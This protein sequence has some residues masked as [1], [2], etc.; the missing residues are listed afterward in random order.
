M[1]F[2]H[3]SCIGRMHRSC[4][5]GRRREQQAKYGVKLLTLLGSTFLLLCSHTWLCLEQKR[6][7]NVKIL[8]GPQTSTVDGLQ[9]TYTFKSS[10]CRRST[11]LIKNILSN[12]FWNKNKD[13]RFI[14]DWDWVAS[15]ALEL[16]GERRDFV[17]NSFIW[18]IYN[19][20]PVINV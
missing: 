13:Q 7:Q 20:Q 4:G 19:L 14:D 18:I 16:S 10:I 9:G 15:V 1:K 8:I 12:Q 3:R 11:R 17:E 6:P 2:W 5:I